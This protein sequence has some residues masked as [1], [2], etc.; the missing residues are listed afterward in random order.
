MTDYRHKRF[1]KLDNEF[2]ANRKMRDELEDD[3]RNWLD[4]RCVSEYDSFTHVQEAVSSYTQLKRCY[5]KIKRIDKIVLGNKEW[6]QEKIAEIDKIE[7]E[8]AEKK[9]KQ[10]LRETIINKSNN[11][12]K[13]DIKSMSKTILQFIFAHRKNQGMY[14]FDDSAVYNE[15]NYII[16]YKPNGVFVLSFMNI[17]LIGSKKRSVLESIINYITN[18]EFI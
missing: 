1:S 12:I 6:M 8:L 14:W 5:K 3:L 17:D 15:D 7:L 4:R 10:E 13:S 2:I 11:T 16:N 18:T 9:I